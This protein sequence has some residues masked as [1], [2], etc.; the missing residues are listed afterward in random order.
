MPSTSNLFCSSE[1]E[2]RCWSLFGPVRQHA[3]TQTLDMVQMST[4]NLP[5]SQVQVNLL[6]VVFATDAYLPPRCREV[7]YNIGSFLAVFSLGLL[8]FW[9][10]PA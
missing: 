8:G 3:R 4:D 5:D 1:S 2:F 9:H 7:K 6:P 10:N